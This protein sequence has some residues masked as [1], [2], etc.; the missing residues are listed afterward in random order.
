MSVMESPETFKVD[1]DKPL[2][3]SMWFLASIATFGLALFPMFYQFVQRRN[4]HFLRLNELESRFRSL[5]SRKERETVKFVLERNA[6]LWAVSLVL[7]VPLFALVYLLS[8]D[9]AA[10]ERHEKMFFSGLL[11]EPDYVIQPIEI[12]KYLVV[13][14]VTLGIGVIYWLYKIINIYNQ[15]FKLERSFEL[16]LTELMEK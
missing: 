16:R 11:Q 14:I 1:K 13:T 15:H 4:N 7:V 12:R 3:F 2:W 5:D 9:L 8:K 10:H 6:S